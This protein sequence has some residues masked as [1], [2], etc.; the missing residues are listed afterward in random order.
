MSKSAP[1]PKSRILLT[2]STEAIRK[3]IASA[4][5]D[6]IREVYW[7]EERRGV[8]NLITI[9]TGCSS[10][11]DYMCPEEDSKR[12]E[13]TIERCK[14]LDHAG[15][16]ALVVDAVE[17]RL[18]GPRAEYARIR[19]E[20]GYLKDVLREGAEAAR[21]VAGNTLR[22]VRRGLGMLPDLGTREASDI[23]CR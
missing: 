4:V 12:L 20:T 5:T 21:K 18:K 3:K 17:E 11:P 13:A 15:L 16:K 19:S 9:L 22:D 7:D 14:G 8:C 10:N 23:G 1:D 2:D 6:S